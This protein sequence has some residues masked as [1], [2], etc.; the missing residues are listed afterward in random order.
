MAGEIKLPDITSRVRLD[1]SDVNDAVGRT[2]SALKSMAGAFVG[3]AAAV[4]AGKFLKGAIEEAEEARKTIAQTNAVIKSTG[5]VAKVTA[6]G[7]DALANRLSNLTGI[8]DEAIAAGENLL[9]TFTNVRNEVGKGNNVFDQATEAALDMSVAMGTD[10]KGA[11]ILVG[12]ALNDPIK[13]VTALTKSGVQFT[14]QQ[15]EQIKTLVESG[16]T[17]DAQ[18][19]ILKELTTQFGG[20]A[21]AAASPMAKLKVAF[22]NLKETV[23]TALM[24]ALSAVATFLANKLPAAIETGKRA[25][26]SI[27]A[28]LAPAVQFIRN[29][30]AAGEMDVTW[31]DTLVGGIRALVGAFKNAGEGITSSGFAG[32]MER[33]GIAARTV[34]EFIRDHAQPIMIGLGVALAVIISPLGVIAAALIYAYTQ[35]EG[36]RNVVDAVV[37]FLTGTVAPAIV[38]VA[39]YIGEQF[40]NLA[41]FVREHWGSIQEAI[42]HVINVVRAIIEEF[43]S[44]VQQVWRAWGD[45]LMNIVGIVWDQIRNTIE[46]VVGIIQGIIEAGLALIN[47]E[48]G[49][50]WDAIKDIL[51]TAWEYIRETVVN[52]LRTLREVVEGGISAVVALVG[53]VPGQILNA[54]GDLGS[55]LYN[56]GRAVISGLLQGIKDAVGAVY[57]FVSG[58]AGKIAS[59]KGPI[60]KDRKLL[61]PAGQAIMQSL[62]Q[63]LR[64]KEN[65]LV[66]ELARITKMIESVNAAAAPATTATSRRTGGSMIY[67]PDGTPTGQYMEDHP[68][69]IANSQNDPNRGQPGYRQLDDGSWGRSSLPPAVH[70]T[71][72]VDR[73]VLAEA[74]SQGQYENRR[75]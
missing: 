38:A 69:Y 59:L 61:I 18:K 67:N 70:T 42:S 57:D 12:K 28:A 44:V 58:I 27:Q 47:G 30:F 65:E 11:S 63:G 56:A 72:I 36:F 5:G 35:F 53:D 4:G 60:D 14:A 75:R 6:E 8:D 25:F 62:V 31:L 20:S 73:K 3:V 43:V 39:S 68:E 40:G 64:D 74:T 22:D 1:T 9:L 13:G 37:G 29:A 33:V 71:I 16:R 21:A 49:A 19:I 52:A 10:M 23:G 15:K 66:R 17:L 46:T 7:V 41:A 32:A 45:E 55:L 24:P 54:L 50:A 26:A 48:W 51:A 2:G 34:F